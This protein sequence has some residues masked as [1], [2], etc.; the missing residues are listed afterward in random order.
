MYLNHNS[1]CNDS[2]VG[3]ICSVDCFS[4]CR[5]EMPRKVTARQREL[6]EEFAGRRPPPSDPPKVEKKKIVSEDETTS[7]QKETEPPKKKGWFS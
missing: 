1:D 7:E 3:K 6:L 5:I 2:N 4:T